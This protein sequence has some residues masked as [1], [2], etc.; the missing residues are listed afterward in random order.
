MGIN[1]TT[2]ISIRT[3]RLLYLKQYIKPFCQ[4]QFMPN[5]MAHYLQ[6]LP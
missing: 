5:N 2:L 4:Y 6:I 3:Q 1:K